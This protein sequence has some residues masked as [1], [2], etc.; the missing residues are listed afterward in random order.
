RGRALGEGWTGPRGHGAQRSVRARRSDVHRAQRRTAVHVHAGDF[1]VRVLRV[2]AGSGYAV[3]AAAR[4]RR[5]AGGLRLDRGSLR[6]VLADP[7]R[8][9]GRADGR[10]RS[11]Q[12]RPRDAGDDEDAEDR[13][14]RPPTGVRPR[15]RRTMKYIL[16]MN[17]PTGGPY[18][19]ATW[20]RKDLE[21]HIAFMKKF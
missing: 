16:M 14:R 10:S 8:R 21:A 19:I 6:L 7:P 12:E 13:H 15:S 18:R 5:Q 1:A 20:P 4:R 2:A 9:A 11:H 3:A 17:T